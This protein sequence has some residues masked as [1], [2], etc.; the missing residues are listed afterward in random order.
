MN[1]NP[2]FDSSDSD[3]P[4]D[5]RCSN[6]KNVPAAS[7]DSGKFA[8][9]CAV[10]EAHNGQE[11]EPRSEHDGAASLLE[12]LDSFWD[13]AHNTTE[14]SELPDLDKLFPEPSVQVAI[15]K[16]TIS[17]DVM[18]DSIRGDDSVRFSVPRNA[19]SDDSR[20]GAVQD[21]AEPSSRS[22]TERGI[23]QFDLHRT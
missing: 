12:E 19:V 13:T 3:T 7:S 21:E 20:D 18:Q 1:D 14:D 2:S 22:S 15:S 8:R 4:Q 9:R 5:L 23:Y 17:E 16:S 6:T 10:V 11:A